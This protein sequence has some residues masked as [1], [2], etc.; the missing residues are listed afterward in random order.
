MNGILGGGGFTSRIMS[1]VRSD[2]GLAYSAGSAFHHGV[3]YEGSFLAAFQSKSPTVAQAVAIVREEIEK[4]RTGRVSDEELAMEKNQIIESFPNRFAN[5]GAIASQFASDY[6]TEL[7][8]DYW[9]TFRDRVRAVTA[10]DVQRVA[11]K[12][13]HPDKLVLLVV[14]NVD[15]ILK[16]NPDQPQYQLTK[17]GFAENVVRIP[18]PDP[19]T[20]VYPTQ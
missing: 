12:Y 17:L 6:Y 7:P 19:L 16:G 11:Q 10:A 4:L 2:E 3:Y 5:A 14:G 20:M 13:L 8:D 15:D 9:Q 1:R 18:L